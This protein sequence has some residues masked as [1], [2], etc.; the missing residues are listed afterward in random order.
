MTQNRVVSTLGDSSI[1]GKNYIGNGDFRSW[2]GGDASSGF[3]DRWT[4]GADVPTTVT[5]TRQS[6]TPGTISGYEAPYY[7]DYV[8]TASGANSAYLLQTIDDV[9]SLAGQTVTLSFW[10]KGSTSFS[11][12]PLSL[13]TF[14]TGG[15]TGVVTS[16]SPMTIGT[17]WQRYTQTF[18]VPSAT[19]KTIGN[20][21][22]TT[23]H[24]IRSGT[25]ATVSVW[26]V[27]LELSTVATAFNVGTPGV[28]IVS[29]VVNT[30]AGSGSVGWSGYQVA[31][32]NRVIN[33]GFDYWQ[34]GTSFGTVNNVYLAD[35][36]YIGYAGG[37]S[38]ASF[39]QQT[40]TPGT[41]PGYDSQFFF[42]S[43]ITSVGSA[44]NYDIMHFIE[45]VRTLSGQ[46][47]TLSFWAKADSLRALTVFFTQT[48]GS[49]G[50]SL[51]VVNPS[52]NAITLTTSWQRFAVTIQLPSMSGK[53]LGANS[54]LNIQLRQAVA[55]GSVL[56]LWGVQLESGSSATSFS[57]AGGTIQGELAACQRYFYRWTDPN[58]SVTPSL[59]TGYCNSTTSMVV[60]MFPRT[61][62]RSAPTISWSSP[63]HFYV[64]LAAGNTSATAFTTYDVS[65]NHVTLVATVASGLTSGQG[66]RVIVNSS[67]VSSATFDFSAE[68]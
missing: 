16:Y 13:Q 4:I 9:R 28:T 33:G 11:S 7:L 65:T 61:T 45:D 54:Y 46:T 39:T 38:T 48:F 2:S 20:G 23:L 43:T 17:T 40:F 21:S 1:A 5:W 12:Q 50:S 51:S 62:M 30:P 34:R 68:L 37:A 25:S 8:I 60:S 63:S 29:D 22:Y 14:G 10:A 67:S 3:P 44:V 53:T 24:V 18:T 19:G 56:D 64:G 36:W 32:K 52:G 59:G 35:R 27:Q 66:G 31:G 57:R 42:R 58:L 55:A 47:A 49:G 15:S 6:F 41:I 26:G